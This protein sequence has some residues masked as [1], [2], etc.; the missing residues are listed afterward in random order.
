MAE[1]VGVD[2]IAQLGSLTGAGDELADRGIGHGAVS[3]GHEPRRRV[4]GQAGEVAP[5]ADFWPDTR[6]PCR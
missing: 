6:K 5:G 1:P 2:G 4:R 3:L